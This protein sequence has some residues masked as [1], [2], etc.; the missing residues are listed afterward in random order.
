MVVILFFTHLDVTVWTN[1]LRCIVSGSSS[2]FSGYPSGKPTSGPTFD[3]DDVS[4][5]P[6]TG[7]LGSESGRPFGSGGGSSAGYDNLPNGGTLQI[8]GEILFW[9]YLLI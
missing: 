2:G 7:L 9:F 3:D 5:S 1:H 8:E 6:D 4:G